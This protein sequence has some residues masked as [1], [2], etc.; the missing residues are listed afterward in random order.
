MKTQTTIDLENAI[1]QN[2]ISIY[3]YGC[4]EVTIEIGGKER[5]DFL[6][7]NFKDIFRCFEIK[8]TKSDLHSKAAL[9][10]AGHLNYLV[11]PNDSELIEDAKAM[12]PRNVG[13]LVGEK[14]SI[15]KR[16]RQRDLPAQYVSMLKTSLIRSMARELLKSNPDEFNKLLRNKEQYK[17]LYY[18]AR[19]KTERIIQH[20]Y[21]VEDEAEE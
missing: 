4:H 11:I 13:L 17:R 2:Y 7:M 19:N 18:Q 1:R 10:W 5:V 3:E 6:T 21:I 20:R 14:L 16:P 12:L 15:I 9:S 8:V